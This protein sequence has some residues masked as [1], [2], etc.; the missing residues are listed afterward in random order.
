[1]TPLDAFREQ[2]RAYRRLG[3][4]DLMRA[5][6]GR[7]GLVIRVR[8]ELAQALAPAASRPYRIAQTMRAPRGTHDRTLPEHMATKEEVAAWVAQDWSR[9]GLHPKVAACL[10][11]LERDFGGTR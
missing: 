6:L 10:T 11:Y 8:E 1:M 9:T 2:W 5:Q 7:A 3:H 4:V